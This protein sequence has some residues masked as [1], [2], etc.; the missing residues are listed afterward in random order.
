M[1][2]HYSNSPLPLQQT[3]MTTLHN[4]SNIQLPFQPPIY[5]S[6]CNNMTWTSSIAA[7]HSLQSSLIVTMTPNTANIIT[8][9]F[10][11][12]LSLQSRTLDTTVTIFHDQYGSPSQHRPL[13]DM[14]DYP[15][16]GATLPPLLP[17]S[18]QVSCDLKL[19]MYTNH[20]STMNRKLTY[21]V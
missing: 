19:T 20:V 6:P 8:S 12:L 9:S 10:P 11:S 18:L 4:I 1:K 21:F 3:Q 14:C 2:Q 5:N 17:L 15:M 7:S 13:H 16:Y